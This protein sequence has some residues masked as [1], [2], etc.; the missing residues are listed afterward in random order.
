MKENPLKYAKGVK[1]TSEYLQDIRIT[2]INKG[3]MF[4]MWILAIREVWM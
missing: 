1:I 4:D 3:A 2:G